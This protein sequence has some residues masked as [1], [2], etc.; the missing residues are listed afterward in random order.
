[1]TPLAAALIAEVARD[2]QALEEL[3]ELLA[4]RLAGRVA[5]PPRSPWLDAGE[6]A[7]Y[8][9]CAKQRIYDLVS[10]GQLEPRRDGRRVLF[11][12]DHLDAY[13]ERSA[14]P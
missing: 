5:P 12:T 13:L 2:P 4:P 7:E 8:L 11:H 9:R 14:T 1:M 3:A 6:A 10:A